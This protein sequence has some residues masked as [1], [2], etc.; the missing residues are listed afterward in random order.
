M[1]NW[2]NEYMA[3]YHRQELIDDSRQKHIEGPERRVHTHRP[4]LVTQIKFNLANWMIGK[5]EDLRGQHEARTFSH[6]H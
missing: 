2:H 5:G 6:A 3:E 4:N 1:N